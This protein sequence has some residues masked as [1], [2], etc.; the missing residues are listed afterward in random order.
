LVI[1]YRKR[2][3]I[4]QK[5]IEPQIRRKIKK[6]GHSDVLKK[7]LRKAWIVSDLDGNGRLSKEELRVL[8][9]QAFDV[10]LS[11][12]ECRVLVR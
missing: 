4:W 1:K 7:E 9:N 5:F 6:M 11:E 3:H 2:E 12:H 8:F 10:F